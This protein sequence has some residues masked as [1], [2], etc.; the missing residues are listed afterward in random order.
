MRNKIL[1][2]KHLPLALSFPTSSSAGQGDGE[3][4]SVPHLL[5][6]SLL[7]PQGHETPGILPLLQ[8]RRQSSTNFSNILLMQCTYSQTAPVWIPFKGCN[9]SGSTAPVWVSWRVASPVSKPALMWASFSIA[10][11]SCQEPAAV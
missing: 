3:W 11:R 10:H 7:P 2:L 4:W 6:L 9:P 1:I 5:S 8:H